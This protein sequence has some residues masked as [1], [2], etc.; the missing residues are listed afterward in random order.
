[1]FSPVWVS[2]LEVGSQHQL[3]GNVILTGDRDA[4]RWRHRSEHRGSGIV[5]D[6]NHDPTWDGDSR[7]HGVLLE[8][9][10]YSTAVRASRE[11]V[12]DTFLMSLHCHDRVS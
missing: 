6:F 12:P 4:S 8:A 5:D 7:R 10:G 1:M 11:S 3:C 2:I 9:C